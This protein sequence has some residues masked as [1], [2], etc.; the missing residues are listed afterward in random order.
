MARRLAATAVLMLVLAPSC[1]SQMQPGPSQPTAA[2]R[3]NGKIAFQSDRDERDGVFGIYVMDAD[4]G[5]VRRLVEGQA[6]A[7]EWAPDGKRIAFLRTTDLSGD[8]IPEAGIYVAPSDGSEEERITQAPVNNF[9]FSWSPDG[10]KIVFTGGSPRGRNT[11]RPD[12]YAVNADGTGE[13]RLTTAPEE[14]GR[15]AWSPDGEKIS[16]VRQ[17]PREDGHDS[18]GWVMNADGTGAV[19]VMEGGAGPL[20]WSPDGTRLAFTEARR[21]AEYPG[22]AIVSISPD[23]TGA[24][25]VGGVFERWSPDGR[26]ILRRPDEIYSVRADGSD[27]RKLPLSADLS[28]VCWSPDGKK[29]VFVRRVD[30]PPGRTTPDQ[31]DILVMNADGTGA[32]NLTNHP[33]EDSAPSWQSVRP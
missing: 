3:S 31:P 14:D 33:G 11:R 5:G 18:E 12:I 4:G 1:T 27:E 9:E 2:P 28:C 15:P 20:A 32:H 10:K 7:P 16:F 13:Q 30:S 17:I 29:I 6:S 19:R 21:S 8:P 24:A 23:G 22:G 26:I 25:R